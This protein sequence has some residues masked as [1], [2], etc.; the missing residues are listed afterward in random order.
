MTTN[1]KWLLGIFLGLFVLAGGII[2]V[3]AMA[4]LFSP[5]SLELNDSFGKRVGVLELEG[6]IDD[7]QPLIRQLKAF[8]E[9]DGIQAVVV[10]VESPGG[11]VAPSQEI[12]QA[13]TVLREKKPVVVSMGSIA[14][15][16]GYYVACGA[17][18]I[19]AAPGTLT[20][21]IGVIL[22][23]PE[24][25]EVLK[26]VGVRFEVVKSG[27]HKDIGSPFRPMTEEERQIMQSMVDDV[28]EQFVEV[29]S[30]ERGLEPDTVRTFADGRVFSGRQALELGLVDA[31]G[32][33]QDAVDMAGRMCGLG[34]N[35]KIT[36]PRKPRPSLIDL[37]TQTASTLN[38]PL[39]AVG[40]PR[41]MYL[42]R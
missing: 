12:Y 33:L 37:L 11:A 16:G 20:G 28:Y 38:D 10:R 22:E 14:A 31:T 15:S 21:S 40:S 8:Q 7:S 18:S 5:S 2:F 41:L 29:V 19:V 27:P 23:F 9:D 35:P 3:M 25:D 30:S 24:L 1:Q 32:S 39:A 4:A 6:V 36:H 26:K 34:E 42:Y 13:L 17:D